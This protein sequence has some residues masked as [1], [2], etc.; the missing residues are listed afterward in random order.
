MKKILSPVPL[1]LLCLFLSSWGSVGHKKINQ[2]MAAC[3]PARMSFLKPSWTTVVTNNASEAD[4]RK[5]QDP[6]EAPR[7]YIDIDNYP[8]FVLS[9]FIAQVYDT[10]VARHGHSFVT[11]QGILPWAT[12]ATFDSVRECF[13][14][15]DWN[16]SALFAA[17]LG[18]YIG[19]GHMP[20]HITRNYDGQYSGQS[21][22][23]SRYEST[24]VGRYAAQIVYPADSA[25]FIP[26]ITAF[27]FNYL[28]TDYKYVDSVLL[29]DT[30]A[31]T[32]GSVGTDAYY[33]SLWLKSG[34]FT[35]LMMRNASDALASLIYTAWVQAGSPRMY[36][37]TIGE[38]V[39]PDQPALLMV[40]P[41]PVR[42]TTTFRV[43]VPDNNLSV[44]LSIYDSNGG[45]RDSVISE[46]LS[47]GDHK[48][49]W[50][51]RNLEPG[52]Y[53]CVLKS[54]SQTI[55]RKFILAP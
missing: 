24:M 25:V 10:N 43:F 40:F 17:D 13:K 32:A 49:K 14:R 9:G 42:Q 36:P 23:H 45:L 44:N 6:L 33:Q 54:G 37:N 50:T 11:E 51:A 19:D 12:I 26:D 47:E 38:P 53:F 52:V 41:N 48:I 34:N 55:T 16:K 20:L 27:I 7:H 31:R 18:H 21:G 29:A 2:N 15:G 30:Y 39:S 8:E 4:N 28:Y 46:R 3:L 1:I 5:S 35:I 22:V